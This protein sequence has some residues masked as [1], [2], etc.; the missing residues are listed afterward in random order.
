MPLFI[1]R[2]VNIQLVVSKNYLSEVFSLAHE[3]VMGVCFENNATLATKVMKY[4]NWLG[5]VTEM[6]RLNRICEKCY[7]SVERCRLD[8][9]SLHPLPN[10]LAPSNT[11][12]CFISKL[13]INK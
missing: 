2:D 5:E 8:F 9:T 13:I 4:Q 6:W 7:K 10:D 11:C 1:I 3:T 12:Y